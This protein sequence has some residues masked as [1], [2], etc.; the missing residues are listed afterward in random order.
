M[1][2][3]DED[4]DGSEDETRPLRRAQRTAA[5]PAYERYADA[6]VALRFVRTLAGSVTVGM[7]LL[8]MIVVAAALLSGDRP[9]PGYGAVT[10]HVVVAVVVVALQRSADR[11][12]GAASV[13]AA[14]GVLA[15]AALTLWI[16]WWS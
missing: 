13:A 2:D 4:L 6:P 5:Y 8:A 9:G 7:V 16:W 12:S 14:F 15:V 1:K 10:G 3:H 11:R